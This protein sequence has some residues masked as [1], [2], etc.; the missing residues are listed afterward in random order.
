MRLIELSAPAFCRQREWFFIHGGERYRP[1]T[2]SMH[3]IVVL[4]PVR[5]LRL[6]KWQQP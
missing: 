3:G 2:G 6:R 5:T 4:L 1:E